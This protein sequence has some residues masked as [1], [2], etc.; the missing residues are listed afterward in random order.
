M[1]SIPTPAPTRRRPSQRLWIVAGLLA[2]LAG[3][4]TI[5]ILKYIEKGRLD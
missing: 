3:G 4:T 1:S 5:A 2:L